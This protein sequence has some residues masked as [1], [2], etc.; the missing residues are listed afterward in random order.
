MIEKL[1]TY[2]NKATKENIKINWGKIKNIYSWRYWA[3]I[4]NTK[5][6]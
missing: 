2:N 6:R 4:H 5:V 1:Q 3:Q